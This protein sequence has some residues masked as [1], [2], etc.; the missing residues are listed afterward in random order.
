MHSIVSDG[1]LYDYSDSIEHDVKYAFFCPAS[2]SGVCSCKPIPF[3]PEVVDMVSTIPLSII[4]NRQVRMN[5]PIF[6]ERDGLQT[7]SLLDD[8]SF[9]PVCNTLEIKLLYLSKI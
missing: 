3:P 5:L 8:S 6:M 9:T 4:K 1:D 2:V 7:G